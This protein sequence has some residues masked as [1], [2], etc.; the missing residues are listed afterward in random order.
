MEKSSSLKG[1]APSSLI[2]AEILERSNKRLKKS[3]FSLNGQALYRPAI[4]RRTFFSA[5][6]TKEIKCYKRYEN[7]APYTYI[8][9]LGNWFRDEQDI[10]TK[11]KKKVTKY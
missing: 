4:K 8:C 10:F 6:L 1:R 2:A 9:N 3:S 11:I 5:S 7:S